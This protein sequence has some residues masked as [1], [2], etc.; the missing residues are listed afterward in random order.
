MIIGVLASMTRAPAQTKKENT[1]QLDLLRS[2]TISSHARHVT[3]TTLTREYRDLLSYVTFLLLYCQLRVNSGEI[4]S[5]I[6]FSVLSVLCS[7]RSMSLL[8][9]VVV[10]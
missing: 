1:L 8:S 4:N 3:S 9:A 10:E 7:A 6:Q 2:F 5:L